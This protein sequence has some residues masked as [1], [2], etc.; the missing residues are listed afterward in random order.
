MFL[1]VARIE[2]KSVELMVLLRALAIL[3]AQGSAQ[4]S[5][6]DPL[7]GKL[8]I[9]SAEGKRLSAAVRQHDQVRTNIQDIPSWAVAM[10][11]GSQF[12][13]L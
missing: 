12:C 5:F 11:S 3:W 10:I 13:S 9:S 1:F 6:E 2:G 7:L 4:R 8:D